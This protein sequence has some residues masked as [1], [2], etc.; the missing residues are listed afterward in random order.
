VPDTARQFAFP[1]IFR[2]IEPTSPRI[3]FQKRVLRDARPPGVTRHTNVP[4]AA[5]YCELLGKVHRAQPSKPHQGMSVIL[6]QGKNSSHS[7]LREMQF[8]W[9]HP[10]NYQ[11]QWAFS[12]I[13]NMWSDQSWCGHRLN[14][15][16]KLEIASVS[17]LNTYGSF[18][19]IFDPISLVDPIT[20]SIILKLQFTLV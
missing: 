11:I 16:L 2:S 18:V 17:R 10:G 5:F 8:Q 7:H 6:Y 15:R 19:C 4:A 3:W 13:L 1:Q 9:D 12:C 20:I 14:H